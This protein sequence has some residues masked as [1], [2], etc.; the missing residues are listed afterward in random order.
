MIEGPQRTLV[1]LAR[2]P[3]TARICREAGDALFDY[4]HNAEGPEQ[5]PDRQRE[6]RP[7]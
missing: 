3:P 7:S 4:Q 1:T 5:S 2:T 6:E